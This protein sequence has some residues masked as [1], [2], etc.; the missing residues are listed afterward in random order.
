VVDAL[1]A[2][3][4]A[5]SLDEYTEA[6]ARLGKLVHDRAYG[7]GFFASASLWFVGKKVPDWGLDKSRGRAPLNLTALVT[8]R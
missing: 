6:T 5:G 8:K 1:A 2:A 3:S 7:P 4:Q